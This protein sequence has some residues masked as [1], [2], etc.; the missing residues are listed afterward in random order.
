MQIKKASVAKLKKTRDKG[1]SALALLNLLWDADRDFISGSGEHADTFI[2]P[3]K[4]F[5]E[6]SWD[7]GTDEVENIE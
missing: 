5:R 4:I 2:S 3:N 7:V 6:G 1:I